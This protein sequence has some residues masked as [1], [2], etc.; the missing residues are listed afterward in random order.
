MTR[1]PLGHSRARPATKGRTWRSL[2]GVAAVLALL[3]LSAVVARRRLMVVTAFGSSMEPT[4]PTGTRLLVLRTGRVRRGDVVV[5]L[6]QEGGRPR[7]DPFASHYLVKRLAALPGDDVPASVATVVEPRDG[8]GPGPAGLSCS[9]TP[10][11]APTDDP[12]ATYRSA[13]SSGSRS[14]GSSGSIRRRSSLRR[15]SRSRRSG[16][17]TARGDDAA[18]RPVSLPALGRQPAP[19]SGRAFAGGDHP[20]HGHSSDRRRQ[21]TQSRPGRDAQLALEEPAHLLVERAGP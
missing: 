3:A 6:H 20:R 2:K 8:R 4:F 5:L 7:A 19:R 14:A 18:S 15:T 9:A 1:L 13:T 17:L 12:G 11:T 10:S 21:L 16:G